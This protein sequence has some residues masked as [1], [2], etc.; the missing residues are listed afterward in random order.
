MRST[1]PTIEKRT[2]RRGRGFY[3][4]MTNYVGS[5]FSTCFVAQI[6]GVHG[7]FCRSQEEKSWIK[8]TSMMSGRSISGRNTGRMNGIVGYPPTMVGTTSQRG[9]GLSKS[10]P[11]ILSSICAATDKAAGASSLPGTPSTLTF[12]LGMK[13]SPKNTDNKCTNSESKILQILSHQKSICMSVYL[14]QILSNSLPQ[15]L[16]L[17]GCVQ[18]TSSQLSARLGDYHHLVQLL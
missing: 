12:M 6:T 10:G 16:A 2:S 18:V 17:L 9:S 13:M 14:T 11:A 4:W 3:H 15:I 5:Y 1:S 8:T 7:F